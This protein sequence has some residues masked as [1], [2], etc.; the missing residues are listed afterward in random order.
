MHNPLDGAASPVRQAAWPHSAT[1]S[2]CG[3]LRVGGHVMRDF[4]AVFLPI[5]AIV[6][7]LAYAFLINPDALIEFGRWLQDFWPNF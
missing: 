6:F 2:H 3:T 4:I 5:G 1:R 7:L